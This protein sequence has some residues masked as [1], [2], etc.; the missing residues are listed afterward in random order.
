[1]GQAMLRPLFFSPADAESETLNARAPASDRDAH[2]KRVL[3]IASAAAR[4]AG[5]AEICR[6]RG[7]ILR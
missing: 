4:L 5:L 6:Q 2:G 7:R 3:G 1:M